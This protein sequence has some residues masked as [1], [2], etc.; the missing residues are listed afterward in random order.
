MTK[1]GLLSTALLVIVGGLSTVRG[2]EPTAALTKKELKSAIA[3]AKTPEDHH[4]IA[5]YFKGQA[6]RLLA[7]AKEHD[8]LVTQYATWPNPAAMKQPMSGQTA[9]HCRYFAEYARKA[10]QQDQELAKMH[11]DMAEQA[12][13]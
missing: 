11:E 8:E 10:A 5:A 9:E 4:R 2:V 13:K 12:A 3:N 1:H 6:D 7:E